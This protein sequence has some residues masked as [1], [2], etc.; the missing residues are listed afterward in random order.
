MAVFEPLPGCFCQRSAHSL[1]RMGSRD[2]GLRH[3]GKTDAEAEQM[4]PNDADS[5]RLLPVILT[6]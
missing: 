3:F 4:R 6:A 2:E 5:E 1:R